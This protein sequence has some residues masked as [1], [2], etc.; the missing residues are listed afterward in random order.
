MHPIILGL[1]TIA[2]PAILAI[3]L[4]E[5]AHGWVAKKCGDPT[6]DRADRLS[7]NPFRHVD[8]IGT[9]LVPGLLFFVA[10]GPVFGWAKPVPVDWRLLKRPRR[11]IALVALAGPGAN[12]LMMIMWIIVARFV[13]ILFAEPTTFALLLSKMCEVGIIVN[14]I[15]MLLNLLPIPPLDGSRVVTV[16]LPTK[17][18]VYYNRIGAYGLL[19]ILALIVTKQMNRILMAPVQWFLDLSAKLAGL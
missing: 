7:L 4:H 11:D 10:N 5:V 18:A 9:V 6:A 12:L 14:V 8:P 13:Q 16:L 2:P 3:T 15:L 17:L 19:I 1:L